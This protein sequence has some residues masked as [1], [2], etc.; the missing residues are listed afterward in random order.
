MVRGGSASPMEKGRYSWKRR[1]CCF[2]WKGV[3]LREILPTMSEENLELA[4]RLFP[5]TIDLVPLLEQA[6]WIDAYRPL[7]DPEFETVGSA[8]GMETTGE[9]TA[10]GSGR[11]VVQGVEGFR[12]A[13]RSF[14]AAW[15]SWV[16]SPTKFVEVDEERVLVLV[17][18]R[19]R[20]KTHEVDVPIDAANLLT[21]RHG[22]L[23]R[24]E[25]FSTRAEA[26]EAAGL[27]Q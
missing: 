21:F 17:D 7:L 14:L 5:G 26:L 2:A 12:D 9:P 16:A 10:E 25:L 24:L 20:S 22:K 3:A 18:V 4:R 1:H 23:R 19:A 15:E 6:D 11:R 27:S 8:L 13:W